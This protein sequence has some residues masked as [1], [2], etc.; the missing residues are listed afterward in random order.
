MSSPTRSRSGGITANGQDSA[1]EMPD[2]VTL[3]LH[4][5]PV[6]P[7]RTCFPD[8][9]SW[10][11]NP[12]AN[13][14]D[15]NHPRIDEVAKQVPAGTVDVRA[16]LE[17]AMSNRQRMG[18]DRDIN[19]NVRIR[20]PYICICDRLGH[21]GLDAQVAEEVKQELIQPARRRDF[22]DVFPV[23]YL[24]V[25]ILLGVALCYFWP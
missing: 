17:L 9:E 14:S 5:A 10:F 25:G 7:P 2:H 20:S 23:W 6:D 1:D 19:T 18:R 11:D 13:G 16:A 8:F 22:F 21:P 12:Q 15:L 3:P 4:V 24:I